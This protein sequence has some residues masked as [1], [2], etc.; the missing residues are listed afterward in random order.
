MLA[1]L[2]DRRTFDEDW[3]FERKLDGVRALATHDANRVRL[4][5]RTG[6]TLNDT[7]P[8]I[9]DALAAQHS[10]DFTIDGEITAIRAGRSDFA[11]LQ[12]RMQLTLPEHARA[13]PVSV[14]YYVF[15]LLRLDGQ[16]TT[17][18]PLRTRKSVLRDA[19]DFHTPL[20]YRNQSAA[21][22]ASARW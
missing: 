15:D 18:L 12:Q 21:R 3:L 17:G 4:F 22:R 13:S 6:K 5:S 14:R 8:E 1:V 19:L 9:V 11:L 20:R 16:D 7:Y 2:T 10:R